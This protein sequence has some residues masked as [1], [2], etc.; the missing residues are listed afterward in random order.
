ML[1]H[2]FVKSSTIDRVPASWLA[3]QTKRYV[4]WMETQVYRLKDK[5]KAA[6]ITA[7]LPGKDG[8]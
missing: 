4:E 7:K 2:Y 1:D 8:G 3:P 5:K 6:L